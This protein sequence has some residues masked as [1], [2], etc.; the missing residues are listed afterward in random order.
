MMIHRNGG[1]NGKA[2]KGFEKY[3]A[4]RLRTGMFTLTRPGAS[5][6]IGKGSIFY[7]RP[8]GSA[9]KYRVVLADYGPTKVFTVDIERGMKMYAISEHI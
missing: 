6:T 9:D 7:I 3:D 5:V 8:A 1:G 4:R 2:V